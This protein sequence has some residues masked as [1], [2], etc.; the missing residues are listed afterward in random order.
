MYLDFGWSLTD[1]CV[2]LCS[3]HLKVNWLVCTE[4][5]CGFGIKWNF[6]QFR[7]GVW[8]L[9]L[10]KI[11]SLLKFDFSIDLLQSFVHLSL[12][13][14]PMPGMNRENVCLPCSQCLCLVEICFWPCCT[15]AT[16]TG[17]I[18]EHVSSNHPR[19]SGSFWWVVNLPWICFGSSSYLSFFICSECSTQPNVTRNYEPIINNFWSPIQC[20]HLRNLCIV[21]HIRSYLH[22]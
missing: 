16:R 9:L 22:F 21:C 3:S 15:S 17:Y 10:L 5:P 13:P 7:G 14:S 4:L 18:I 6:T 8:H 2:L 11:F 20:A 1:T 12:S 19:N